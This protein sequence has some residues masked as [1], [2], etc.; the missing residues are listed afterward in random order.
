MANQLTA[1]EVTSYIKGLV[2]EASP[3]SFP[4]N[5]SIEETNFILNKDGTRRRRRGLDFESDYSIIDTLT[6]SSTGINNIATFSFTWKNPGGFSDKVFLVTQVG[7]RILVLDSTVTPL[8]SSL[9]YNTTIAGANPEQRFSITNVDGILVIAS[10]QRLVTTLSYDGSV[11]SLES[12]YLKVRDL[13]GVQDIISSNLRE[14]TGLA[15]RPSVTTSAHTYNLRNQTWA[16]PRYVA[17]QDVVADTIA[18]FKSSFG[19]YQSN[20]DSLTPVYYPNTQASRDKVSSR[21]NADDLFINPLGTNL[22][23]MGYFVIDALQRGTSRLEEVTKLQSIYPQLTTLVSALP[24]DTTPGGATVLGGFAGRVWYGGFS[25][26]LI[27]G[28]SLSPRMTSYIL[29]SKL[30]SNIS[31]IYSCYQEGDPT[32]TKTP[33]LVATDGGF[34]RLDGAYNIQQMVN[35]GDALMVIAENGVWKI[36]GGSN[37]GFSATNYLTSKVTEHGSISPNSIVLVDNTFM[38]WSDDGIYHVSPNQFGDWQ[39]VNLTN[40]TIQRFF[41]GIDFV[42]KANVYGAYDA[43][44]RRIRWLYANR[45]GDTAPNKELILDIGI[46]AFYTNTIG[47]FT[48]TSLPRAV[49]IVKVPPFST[50]LFVDEV[51]YNGIP[52]VNSGDPVV[53]SSIQQLGATS[54]L[55]YLVVTNTSGT[56]KITFASYNNIQFRDWYSLDGVGI[57]AAAHMITGWSGGGDFQRDKQVP[58]LTV[59]SYKTETGFTPAFSPVNESSIKIRSMWDWSNSEESGKWSPEFQ[60]YRHNRYWTPS[61]AFSEFNDGNL[62][63]VTKN[64]LRGRGKV[65]SLLFKT[66][67][68]KDFNLIGWSM[69][70]SVNGTV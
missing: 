25:S 30:V 35:V 21:F 15:I 36:T 27:G 70:L 17:N 13:F 4:E 53:V 42:Y 62:V 56:I 22:A 45:I 54:E 59:Y 14:G 63:V 60:A 40:S 29:F 44:E 6:P 12:N 68:Y 46:G 64:K 65:L 20:S 66:E 38:Y 37:Y 41:D 23:P 33:E 24:Q 50:N 8:S 3:M 31:D 49:G 69:L 39:A 48:G 1:V 57:D 18:G 28:D 26:Q 9:L 52:V 19:V 58:Y 2:T 47:Q 67:P 61:N 11:F 16:E 7:D 34:L 51:Y 5:A 43:Y 10:G 55:V 32:S